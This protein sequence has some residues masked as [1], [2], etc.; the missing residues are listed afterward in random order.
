MKYQTTQKE[1][2]N[3]HA[4]I[5]KM[6]CCDMQEL[7]SLIPANAY[8]C[9]V[10]GWN[11]DIYESR[12]YNACIVTGYRP[13]GNYTPD[14]DKIKEYCEYAKTIK[15]KPMPYGSRQIE[16]EKLMEEFFSYCVQK[17]YCD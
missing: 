13:F 10:Y 14:R 8:T 12:R 9:G 11:A 3:G 2:R 1:V 4:L 17:Y 7:L 6:G 15:S 5:I 16:L